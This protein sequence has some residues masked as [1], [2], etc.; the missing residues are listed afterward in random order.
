M[1]R[2]GSGGAGAGDA[3]TI[4]STA[5]VAPA[6]RRQLE[7]ELLYR[8]ELHQ[9]QQESRGGGRVEKRKRRAMKNRESA[10]R[11]RARKQAYLQELEEELRLL[12]AENAQLRDQCHQLKAAAAK[13]AEAEAAAAEQ[14]E[15]AA[16]MEAPTL[17]RTLSATF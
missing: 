5:A 8:A 3:A 1:E 4:M 9:Q 10:E 6:A 2:A 17:K 14:Q 16:A 13:A 7:H 12:R 11:S 15:A